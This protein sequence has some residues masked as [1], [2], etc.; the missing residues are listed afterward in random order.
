MSFTVAILDIRNDK[1][2]LNVARFS[3]DENDGFLAYLLQKKV[4][5]IHDENDG[6]SADKRAK[7]VTYFGR[8]L[9]END[10]I[11]VGDL[12]ISADDFLDGNNGRFPQKKSV[13]DGSWANLLKLSVDD[14]V[15][16]MFRELMWI[17]SIPSNLIGLSDIEFQWKENDVEIPGGV[18]GRSVADLINLFRLNHAS[19]NEMFATSLFV[20]R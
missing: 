17:K 14:A 6:T 16:N 3:F 7:T 4:N 5:L 18:A 11:K 1:S 19:Q 2:S 13:V 9:T 12:D 10:G 20:L 8:K 15:R